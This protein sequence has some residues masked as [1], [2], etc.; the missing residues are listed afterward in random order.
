MLEGRKKQ[1]VLQS[2]VQ[3]SVHI[4]PPHIHGRSFG[5]SEGM[6]SQVTKYLKEFVRLSL[7]FQRLRRK[8]RRKREE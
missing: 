8:G 1:H 5:N 6:R 4:Y 2:V 7:K 3:E